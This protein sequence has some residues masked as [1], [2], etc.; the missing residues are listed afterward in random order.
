V[1][2]IT[3][4]KLKLLTLVGSIGAFAASYYLASYYLNRK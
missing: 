2:K 1:K 4:K 3:T